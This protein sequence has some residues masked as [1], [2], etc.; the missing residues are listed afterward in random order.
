MFRS[1]DIDLYQILIPKDNDWD[2]MNELGHLNCLQFVNLNTGAQSHHLKY[3]NQVKRA[4]DSIR[5]IE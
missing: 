4:D 5:K 2:I 1:E 3:F